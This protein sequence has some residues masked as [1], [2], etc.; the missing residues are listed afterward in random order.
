MYLYINLP[1]DFKRKPSDLILPIATSAYHIYMAIINNSIFKV[2]NFT[3]LICTSF[4]WYLLRGSIKHDGYFC[5]KILSEKAHSVRLDG[6]TN[7]LGEGCL[8]VNKLPATA[9]N[10]G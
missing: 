1:T 4:T 6:F 5:Q 2:R 3:S 8:F 10:L 7:E 9:Q